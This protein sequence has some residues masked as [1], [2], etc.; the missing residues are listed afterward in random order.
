MDYNLERF[1]SA[2]QN[3]YQTALQEI[4]A[5][6]KHSHWMWFIFPQI[7][8]LGYSEMARYYAIRDM[9][10]AKAYMED[11]ML[12]QNLVEISEAL[13]ET[14]SSDAQEVMGWPD[15]LKLKSSMT[16]FAL[17]K[18]ECEVFQKVLDKFFHGE[19][20]QKTVEIL[21]DSSDIVYAQK[22]IGKRKDSSAMSNT[23]KIRNLILGEGIPK[24]CVPVMGRT[25]QEIVYSVRNAM[26]QGPDMIEWRA[27]FLEEP[28]A[29]PER[30][31]GREGTAVIPERAAG[32]EGTEVFPERAGKKGWLGNGT[33]MRE[34]LPDILKE[35]RGYLG[36]TPL[37]VTFRTKREGGEQEISPEAYAQMYRVVLESGMA[38][39][40]DV[41]LFFDRETAVSLIEAAHASGQKVILSNHDF[42]KT[43]PKE[44]LVR[45]L[46]SMQELGG[47]I[48][49]IAVMPQSSADVL[50]LLEATEEAHRKLSVPVVTMSMGA[51]GVVSRLL[52][53]TFGSALTFGMAGQAS[54]PGQVPVEDLRS[55][56]Q[57]IHRYGAGVDAFDY[58]TI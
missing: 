23:V 14:E 33:E 9:D 55:I 47:D 46:K 12:G 48:A 3:Y 54:A 24:I 4:K 10:E 19:P 44:E 28:E 39:A 36:D 27:D 11:D 18:P 34:T 21:C 37:L 22:V 51:V 45:R 35:L 5:G 15:N 52:G 43:P 29:F 32:R 20:D 7:A 49:K 31:A 42:Q 25:R 13:L 8:G 58:R 40:I 6:Q 30:A 53:E 17:A 16:L 50:I 1:R 57:K 41:E 56:L 38:D 26:E 2:Q